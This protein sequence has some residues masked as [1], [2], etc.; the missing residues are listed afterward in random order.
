MNPNIVQGVILKLQW[1]QMGIVRPVGLN[2]LDVKIFLQFP[3]IQMKM[4]T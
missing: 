3:L 1:E 4:T 2:D